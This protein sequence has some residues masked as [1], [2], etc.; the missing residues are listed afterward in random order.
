MIPLELA[1]SDKA[2][3]LVWPDG[4][5]QLAAESLRRAC[6]CAECLSTPAAASAHAAEVQLLDLEAVGLYAVRLLFSDG[7]GRGI[8]PWAY[9]RTLGEDGLR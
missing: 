8:Y 4:E 9:L 2:L 7:H 5:T 6:R 1:L 3:A